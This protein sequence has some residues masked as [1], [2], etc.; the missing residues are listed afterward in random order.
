MS[1]NY[2]TILR[3][4]FHFFSCFM[5]AVVTHIKIYSTI[6]LISRLI[7]QIKIS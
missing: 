5:N 6:S 3:L 2:E 7:L 1:L 4:I